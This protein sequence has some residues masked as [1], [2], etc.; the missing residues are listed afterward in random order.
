MQCEFNLN[1]NDFNHYISCVEKP[2]K[3]LR[4][5][6]RRDLVDLPGLQ[7]MEIDAKI[8]TGAY[9]S[10]LHVKSIEAFDKEGEPWVRFKLDHPHHPAFNNRKF[11]M[12][13]YAHKHIKSS[14]G[15]AELRYVIRT[16]IVLFGRRYT[17]EF[18]LT[19][20]SKMDFPVLLGRK[21][22][23]RKFL[24]DVTQK[25]LSFKLKQKRKIK[26]EDRDSVTF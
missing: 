2:P 26:N 15:Q 8:D 4:T 16:Q 22:L 17:A 18:S 5:I 1:G 14:T 7:L 20:R 25:N 13:V 9:T 23:Y 10:A 3:R 11:K 21:L 6:G 12:P 24:V 19:D